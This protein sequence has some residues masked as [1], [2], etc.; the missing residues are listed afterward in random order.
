MKFSFFYNVK[1]PRQKQKSSKESKNPNTLIIHT[2][3]PLQ[4]LYLTH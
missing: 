4:I 2:V 1:D 3:L